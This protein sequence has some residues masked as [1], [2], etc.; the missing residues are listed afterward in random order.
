[1]R[2]E[3]TIGRSLHY[4]LMNTLAGFA[5]SPGIYACV[6]A[7]INDNGT[8]NVCVFD[9][10]GAPFPRQDVALVQDGDT[11]PGGDYCQ[12]MPFQLAQQAHV[13]AVEPVTAAAVLPPAAP[14]GV[15]IGA[16]TLMGFVG[17]ESQPQTFEV[18]NV[19]QNVAQS[20]AQSLASTDAPAP[21]PA[22]DQS[23]AEQAAAI[24]AVGQAAHADISKPSP[25]DAQSGVD[26]GGT[27]A[28]EQAPLI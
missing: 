23:P 28:A 17:N 18:Q 15:D 3:P 24:E 2:I 25:L 26:A 11:A 19:V 9:R 12:W 20:V 8:I 5:G 4:V 22:P 1:M 14:A 13:Q 7:G 10:N 21:P 27:G 6:L 16:G